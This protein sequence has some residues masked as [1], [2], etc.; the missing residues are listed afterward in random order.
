MKKITFCL[1]PTNFPDFIRVVYNTLSTVVVSPAYRSTHASAW[2]ALV[3]TGATDITDLDETMN[4]FNIEKDEVNS[5]ENISNVINELKSRLPALGMLVH[6]GTITRSNKLNVRIRTDIVTGPEQTDEEGENDIEC[7]IIQPP[8]PEDTT[9]VQDKSEEGFNVLHKKHTFKPKSDE[10]SPKPAK[11]SNSFTVL[12]EADE[13][14]EPHQHTPNQPHLNADEKK[15]KKLDTLFDLTQPSDEIL[16]N[17]PI[18]SMEDTIRNA[19]D[20]EEDVDNIVKWINNV[21]RTSMVEATKSFTSHITEHWDGIKLQRTN[22]VHKKIDAVTN[23]AI[24]HINNAMDT[25]ITTFNQKTSEMMAT[26]MQ[27]VANEIAKM[28]KLKK[29][30]ET[31][32]QETEFKVPQIYNTSMERYK[33]LMKDQRNEHGRFVNK[34]MDEMEQKYTTLE[35]RHG[36][37]V[38]RWKQE[39]ISTIQKEMKDA[40]ISN[41]YSVDSSDTAVQGIKNHVLG[42]NDVNIDEIIKTPDKVPSAQR[43]VLGKKANN[44][45][46]RYTPTKHDNGDQ[47]VPLDIPIGSTV[48][49]H[50]VTD[51]HLIILEK[52]TRQG[53]EYLVGYNHNNTKLTVRTDTVKEV[54]YRPPQKTVQAPR[55]HRPSPHALFPN[56]IPDA[57]VNNDETRYDAENYAEDEKRNHEAPM[58]TTT[59]TWNH[60]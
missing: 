21:T 2:K 15:P 7:D 34:C 56:V 4:F 46:T 16:A 51:I 50:M 24:D 42:L 59:P 37:T 41:S 20:N 31:M 39:I 19:Q 23:T 30:M 26:S 14:E 55:T 13:A 35:Y 5:T 3:T 49:V 43:S 45:N 36:M 1:T 57:H 60:R 28:H 9:A 54:L 29:D 11:I 25:A 22:K 12:A 6:V 52:F 58:D 27:T 33:T 17:P 53:T 48:I 8:T 18:H 40:P 38:Q 47:T 10:E 32:R 44:P